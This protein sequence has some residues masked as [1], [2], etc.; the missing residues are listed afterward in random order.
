MTSLSSCTWP[1]RFDEPADGI[2]GA[3]QR[4]PETRSVAEDPVQEQVKSHV[5]IHDLVVIRQLKR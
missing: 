3:G 5:L 2:A 4:N 1:E